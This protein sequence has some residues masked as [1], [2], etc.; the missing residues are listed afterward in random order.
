MENKTFYDKHILVHL[1]LYAIT[2]IDVSIKI[3]LTIHVFIH[4]FWST[5]RIPSKTIPSILII[6]FFVR[7]NLA[8]FLIFFLE[9][10]LFDLLLVCFIILLCITDIVLSIRI[11]TCVSQPLFIYFCCCYHHDFVYVYYSFWSCLVYPDCDNHIGSLVVS[12]NTFWYC[13]HSWLVT[14]F[15]TRVTRE[16]ALLEQELSILPEHMSSPPAFSGIRVSRSLVLCAMFC[17]SL[18]VLFLLAIVLSV[19]LRFTSFESSNSS[20]LKW[21]R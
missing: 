8:L 1:Y 3:K 9:I 17:R 5:S 21:G 2:N 13:H 6:W 19:L 11:F 20:C 4:N 15:V 14:G 12:V 7:H 18:F 10:P 16:V